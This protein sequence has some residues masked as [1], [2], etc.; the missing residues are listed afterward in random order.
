MHLFADCVEVQ[1]VWVNIEHMIRDRLGCNIRLNK[2]IIVLG[3]D[4]DRLD[5]ETGEVENRNAVQRLILLGKYY[6]YRS[7][8]GNGR[9]SV[10]DMKAFFDFC[11]KAEFS[12]LTYIL[13]DQRQKKSSMKNINNFVYNH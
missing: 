1:A 13:P 4:E 8:A 2:R 5:G 11:T 9:I 6:I 10:T 3:L 7:K 12:S